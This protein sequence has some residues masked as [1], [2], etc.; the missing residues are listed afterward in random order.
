MFELL[1]RQQDESTKSMDRET[2]GGKQALKQVF[3]I[4]AV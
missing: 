1:Q 4:N 2:M 3:L